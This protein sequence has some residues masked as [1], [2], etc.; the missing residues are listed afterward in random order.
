M[1]LVRMW[2]GIAGKRWR[3]A[4]A[5]CAGSVGRARSGSRRWRAGGRR[6]LDLL[7][8]GIASYGICSAGRRAPTACSYADGVRR[9]RVAIFCRLGLF[10]YRGGSGRPG[11]VMHRSSYARKEMVSVSRA[12]YKV[13]FATREEVISVPS[14]CAYTGK[15]V[16]K[17]GSASC[18]GFPAVRRTRTIV[19]GFWTCPGCYKTRTF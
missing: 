17:T 12:N 14:R 9:Q 11:P 13:S 10:G 8:L 18:M 7:A 3:V 1:V 4:S 19:H 2:A 16:R 6:S 15:P 5:S